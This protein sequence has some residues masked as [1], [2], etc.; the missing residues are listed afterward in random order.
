MLPAP[1]SLH[2]HELATFSV[3]GLLKIRVEGHQALPH[4]GPLLLVSNRCSLLDPWLLALAARRPV[5]AAAT[6][7]LFWLPGL[8]RLA[9]RL[10]TIALPPAGEQAPAEA[11]HRY[12]RALEQSHAVVLFGDFKIEDRPEGPRHG[13]P[14]AFLDVLLATS[15]ERIPVI[16]VLA[17]GR[18]WEIALHKHPLLAPLVRAGA[19]LVDTPYP[20]VLYADNTLRIGRPVY[21]RDGGESTLED[22]RRTLELGLGAL[23]V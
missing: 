17:R 1:R 2:L 14:T 5:Y 16:P 18:G 11:A 12:A 15:S 23:L 8:G 10:N 21:W 9:G 22:F 7:P 3:P 19:R 20:P 4:E 6:S 13:I